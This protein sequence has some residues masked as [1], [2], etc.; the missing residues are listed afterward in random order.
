MYTVG[1]LFY[2]IYF[3]VSFPIFFRL[4]EDRG[5]TRT[6]LVQSA[7]QSLAATMLVTLLLDFWRLAFGPLSGIKAVAGIPWI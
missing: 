2:A 5:S 7:G 6:S 3:F 1:S 4:D